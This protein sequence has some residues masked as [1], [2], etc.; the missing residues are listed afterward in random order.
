MLYSSFGSMGFPDCVLYY[1]KIHPG[2][3]S[4]REWYRGLAVQSFSGR[5]FLCKHNCIWCSIS[6]GL[7][8]LLSELLIFVLHYCRWKGHV[9]ILMNAT[10]CGKF[11]FLAPPN[12]FLESAANEF[13]SAM[14]FRCSSF[15]KKDSSILAVLILFF[16]CL[17]NPVSPALSSSSSCWVFLS[18]RSWRNLQQRFRYFGMDFHY[19]NWN[20][21]VW[22]DS[23]EQ[24]AM[25]GIYEP[26]PTVSLQHLQRL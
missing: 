11:K 18:L 9:D 23:Q 19:W 7:H 20:I 8:V 16:N 17:V 22:I 21:G 25:N 5:F 15:L 3:L 4:D 1:C 10:S 24:I 14:S 26:S 2:L 12:T 6:D 13:Y